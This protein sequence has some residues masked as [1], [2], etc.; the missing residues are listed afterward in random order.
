[1]PA[2]RFATAAVGLLL[3]LAFAADGTN[4]F[5]KRDQA[6]SYYDIETLAGGTEGDGSYWLVPGVMNTVDSPGS[7]TAVDLV[8][9]DGTD[10]A[11]A[12]VDSLADD[13]VIRA[14]SVTDET[15]CLLVASAWNGAAIS[16]NVQEFVVLYSISEDQNRFA[17]NDAE[18]PSEFDSIIKRQA[19]SYL[20]MLNSDN[21]ALY[22]FDLAKA[23]METVT[24]RENAWLR[25]LE[26]SLMGLTAVLAGVTAALWVRQRK[27][28]AVEISQRRN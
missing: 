8:V 26:Y 5:E 12:A 14:N 22:S 21:S 4:L 17:A 20:N 16:D 10:N 2:L 9:P 11:S 3:V 6:R 28:K 18:V 25:P 15:S 7:N 13:D 19:G 1:M 24:T 23:T 27:L